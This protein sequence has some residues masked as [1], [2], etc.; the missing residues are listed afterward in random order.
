MTEHTNPGSEG[1]G[2]M[3]VRNETPRT[4]TLSKSSSTN[5]LTTVTDPVSKR[6]YHLMDRP[7]DVHNF[8]WYEK[9]CRISRSTLVRGRN[10]G[11]LKMCNPKNKL[12]NNRLVFHFLIGERV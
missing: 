3:D 4:A 6:E 5:W 12:T 10:S 9:N 2:R 1:V 7:G 8:A 11:R